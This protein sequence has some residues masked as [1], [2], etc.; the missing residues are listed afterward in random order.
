MAIIVVVLLL[1]VIIVVIS[2]LNNKPATNTTSQTNPV[3]DS[4]KSKI[5]D[6]QNKLA[7]S[8]NDVGTINDL[9]VALYATGD[10][11]G[12]KEQYLKEAEVNP[13]DPVLYN[14]LGNVYRDSGEYQKAV[15]AYQKSIDLD[16]QQTNAYLNL[17]NLYLYTLSQ[18]DLGIGVLN[19][20]IANNPDSAESMYLQIGNSYVVL[21]QKDLAKQAYN[22]VLE[23][24]PS[25]TAATAAL[26]NL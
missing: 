20:A 7:Q 17:A 3:L 22:K 23:I 8:P 2:A 19:T 1:G 25:N 6:L 15:D 24:N 21:S 12:A 14:N 5:P 10:V 18:V 16:K 13:S 4:Y 26:K 11:E 9:A